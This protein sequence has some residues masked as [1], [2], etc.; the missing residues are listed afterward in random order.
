MAEEPVLINR[1]APRATVLP[2][3]IYDDVPVASEWLCAA[4]GFAERLRIGNHRAQ[5]VY[6]DGGVIVRDRPDGGITDVTDPAYAAP[7][8]QH[9]HVSVTDSDAHHDRAVRCGAR[10]LEPP[11]DY[12]YG[13]R[14]YT[15]VD[16]GGHQWTFS[17]S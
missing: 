14:Q 16:L 8:R 10:I 13:E 3:L 7:P 9:V 5:L 1:S 15:A 11:T 4:F 12:F 6:R 17:E 2:V